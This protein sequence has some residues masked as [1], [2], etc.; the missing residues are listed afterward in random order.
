MLKGRS[1]VE[2][3]FHEELAK[4]P[5]V[6]ER[7]QDAVPVDELAVAKE[8]SYVNQRAAGDG[9][10]LVGDAWGFIDPVYSSG[11]YFALKSAELAADAVVDGLRAGNTSAETLGRWVP[12]FSRQTNLIR[13]LVHAFYS[14][15]FRVGKFLAEY[16][17]HQDELVDLLI[18]RIFDGREGQIFN[19][20]EPWLAAAEAEA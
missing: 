16:P 10:V 3:T 5:G 7:L 2:Q 6:V 4:C 13:R 18:G 17:E 19:D 12:E 15:S 20:L 11:V 9:W 8:F 1:S 14:K